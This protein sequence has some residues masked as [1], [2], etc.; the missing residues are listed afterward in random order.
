LF[1][2]GVRV[3]LLRITFT[4]LV[5]RDKGNQGGAI[6]KPKTDWTIV[7]NVIAKMAAKD[8][9]LGIYRTHA[10]ITQIWVVT[11]RRFDMVREILKFDCLDMAANYAAYLKDC[12]HNNVTLERE[13]R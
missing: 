9:H 4:G 3:Y 13:V 10:P 7:D 5:C 8:L 6:V 12:G 1:F 2:F 11:H